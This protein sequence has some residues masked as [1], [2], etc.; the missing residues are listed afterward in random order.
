MYGDV[1]FTVED[2][3]LGAVGD[4]GAGAH[5]KIGVSPIESSVPILVTGTM[6]VKK[7]REKLGY[8]PLADACM[9]S[10]SSGTNMIYCIPVKAS[11]DGSVGEITKAGTGEST[12]TVE[13]KPYSAYKVIVEILTAGG[14]N[15]AAFKYSIDGGSTYSEE[16]TVPADGSYI[17][18]AT[19]LTLKFAEHSTKADSYKVGDKLSFET[20]APQMTNQDVLG[21]VTKLKSM[22][23]EFEFVHIVGTST[24]ALWAAMEIEAEKFANDYKIPLFFILEA[25]D[26]NKDETLDAYS[27]ALLA[28]RKGLTSYRIQVVQGRAKFTKMDGQVA[29]VNGAAIICGLYAKASVN[30]SIGKVSEF[31]IKGVLELLPAGIGDYNP[32][33]D[34]AG[35]VTFRQYQGIEGFYVSNARTMAAANSDYKYAERVRTMNKVVKLCRKEAFKYLQDDI[36]MKDQDGSLKKMASFIKIPADKMIRDKEISDV[37]IIVPE[38]QNVLSDEKIEFNLRVTPNAKARAIMLNVGMNNPLL[39]GV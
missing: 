5:V 2:G 23:Q 13:G 4:A 25:R 39:Q 1:G 12:I 9:D 33:L 18:S 24:K 11:T 38:G 20:T 27:T 14:F 15:E 3:L 31:A 28:E 32:V 26:I 17:L 8:S 35:Y 37:E 6:D 16:T 22:A 19:G 36:D 29:N 34:S 10:V 21:A 30:E 7:I